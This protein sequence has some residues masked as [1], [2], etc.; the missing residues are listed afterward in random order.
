MIEYLIFYQ[1]SNQVRQRGLAFRSA[2]VTPLIFHT[3]LYISVLKIPVILDFNLRLI[4]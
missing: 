3:T 1:S 2:F 4:D